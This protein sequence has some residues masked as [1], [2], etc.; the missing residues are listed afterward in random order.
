[1]DPEHGGGPYERRHHPDSRFESRECVV[2][3]SLQISTTILIMS[4]RTGKSSTGWDTG[5]LFLGSEGT[6]GVRRF[7]QCSAAFTFFFAR[8]TVLL[9]LI[10]ATSTAPL[11][12]IITELTVRLAPVLPLKVALTSFPTISRAVSTVVSILTSGLSPTSLELLDGTSIRGLNLARILPEELSEEPTVLMRFSNTSD[13][14]NRE[15]LRKVAGIVRE[16]GGRELRI[17]KDER[18]N[19]ELWKA[20][21]VR[22]HLC[23]LEQTPTLTISHFSSCRANTGRSSCSLAKGAGLSCVF[24]PVRLSRSG[25]RFPPD[26]VQPMKSL[27]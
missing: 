6:L 8:V 14:V 12:Q 25:P 4:L 17:A 21:K 13:E 5:R 27:V 11:P 10:T 26:H 15:N 24:H 16:N 1:M 23:P 7:P 9:I 18:E 22:S 19:D 20:R 3:P 2:R